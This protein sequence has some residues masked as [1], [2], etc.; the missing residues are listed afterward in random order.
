M[1][2]PRGNT[3]LNRPSTPTP[4]APPVVSLCMI[5]CDEEK[6][7]AACLASAQQDVDEIIVVDTGSRDR[8]RSIARRHG[9]RVVDFRWRDDFAAARN[10][11]LELATGKWILVLDCDERISPESRGLIRQAADSAAADALHLRL[12]NVDPHGR[13]SA[14]WQAIRM[15]R[16]DAGVRYRGRIHERPVFPLDSAAAPDW[17]AAPGVTILHHGY[18]ASAIEQ[19]DK[20]ARNLRLVEKALE[21]IPEDD[22]IERSL[23]LFYYGWGTLG[24]EREQR[25]RAWV[26][27]VDARPELERPPVSA[28][29]PTGLGQYAWALSDQ[30]RH[31]EAEV[32]A[33]RV[34]AKHGPSL[35][36]YLVIARARAATGDYEAAEEALAVLLA[37]D[38]PVSDAYRHFPLD[39]GLVRRRAR[40]LQAEVAERHEQY[41]EAAKLYAALVREEPDYL[42]SVLRLAC[43]EVQRG[44]F[45]EA[46]STI[47]RRPRLLEQGLPEI[48]CLCLALSLAIRSPDQA[49]WQKRVHDWVPKSEV[50]ARFQDQVSSHPAGAAFDLSEFPEIEQGI[51]VQLPKTT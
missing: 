49:K 8:T 41:D 48:D 3:R 1:R 22:L 38:T 43:V 20:A 40:H 47:Q 33:R 11:G 45:A 5:T 37:P 42:P 39:A 7:I 31:A 25:I 19:R 30:R 10:H 15:F 14:D 44:R 35:P 6:N 32:R 50:A 26:E 34:L 29:I 9:A 51:R 2:R 17:P 46:L 27:F 36:L 12:V 16:T 28:W 4:W 21:E 23:Y 13:Q 24:P 18:Q